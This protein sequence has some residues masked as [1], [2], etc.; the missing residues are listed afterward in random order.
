[1]CDHIVISM[2]KPQY[3]RLN[4]FFYTNRPFKCINFSIDICSVGQKKNTRSQKLFFLFLISLVQLVELTRGKMKRII[5]MGFFRCSYFFPVSFFYV[6]NLKYNFPFPLCAPE[7][8][9][10]G[11]PDDI[12]HMAL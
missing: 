7:Q 1:M 9:Q 10:H 12:V 3:K 6:T 11:H 8:P 5:S 2:R 4:F